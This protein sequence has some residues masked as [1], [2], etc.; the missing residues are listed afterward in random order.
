MPLSRYLST[1]AVCALAIAGLSAAPGSA[2]AQQEREVFSEDGT[3]SRVVT[4]VHDEVPAPQSAVRA[5]VVPIQVTG[6]SDQRFDLV[7]V[8][9]GYT[10]DE[11]DKYKQD[12]LNRWNEMIQVEPFKSEQN[13]FDVWAVNVVSQESGVSNDP[14]G[15]HRS[16]ALEMTFWC[17]GIERLLCVNETKALQFA[18]LAPAADQ[19]IALAN[20]TKYGG[21]G[22]RVATSSGQNV[23]AGQIVLHELGHSIGGLADEY[24]YPDDTYTG[25]EPREPNAST[26]TAAQMQQNQTKWYRYLGKQSPDGGVVDTY[27]GAVYHKYGVY[28]PTENSLMRTLGHPYNLIGLDAMKAA[29]ERKNPTSQP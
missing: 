17:D 9:D 1:I 25:P 23:K 3:I 6:P 16:T 2:T 28:R 24:D 13:S 27:E 21:A 11:L 22:G 10:S 26:Y 29:I 14:Q 18:G 8:G 15:T 20:T 19:V 4:P 5:D 12:V 7:F